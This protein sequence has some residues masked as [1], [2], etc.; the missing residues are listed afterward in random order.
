MKIWNLFITNRHAWHR[1]TRMGIEK[2]HLVINEKRN[3][4]VT[5]DAFRMCADLMCKESY[6]QNLIG[7]YCI[8]LVRLCV[9]SGEKSEA[10]AL[11]DRSH[12]TT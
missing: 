10:E 5:D 11:L 1:V 9:D 3:E 12:S 6:H 2:Y 7:K 4:M 8:N